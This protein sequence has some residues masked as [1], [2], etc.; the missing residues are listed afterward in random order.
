MSSSNPLEDLITWL[1][2][3][4]CLETTEPSRKAGRGP[5]QGALGQHSTKA[6]RPANT[7]LPACPDS[8]ECGS[9]AFS[10][11]PL[12]TDGRGY[13]K[14]LKQEFRNRTPATPIRSAEDYPLVLRELDSLRGNEAM[15]TGSG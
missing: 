2:P 3:S 14:L 10:K 6:G 7:D 8:V 4:K 5:G 9:G 11:V 15:F 1:G 12:R 13:A